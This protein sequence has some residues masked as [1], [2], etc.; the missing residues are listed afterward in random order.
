MSLHFFED[1]EDYLIELQDNGVGFE[2]L[3]YGYGLKQMME[4]ISILGGQLQFE[5]RD[6]FSR[7]SVYRN[8]KKGDRD[9][10]KSNGGR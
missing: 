8:I 2:T 5:S 6:G 10:D 4:R 3:T 7:A 9:G 1:E